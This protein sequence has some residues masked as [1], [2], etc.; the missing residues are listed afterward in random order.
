MSCCGQSVSDGMLSHGGRQVAGYGL[1]GD[2]GLSGAD[3]YAA[4]SD[5]QRTWI[6]GAMQ[7]FED[8]IKSK[9]AGA[10]PAWPQS[11]QTQADVKGA[12]QCTQAWIAAGGNA[13]R[14][15]GVLDEETLCAIQYEAYKIPAFAQSR[16]PDP[17]GKFCKGMAAE[18]K[19]NTML[20]VAGGVAAVVILG[21][22]FYMMRK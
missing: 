11:F 22:A 13:I 18:K 2:F 3:I 9:G 6:V 20:Y 10:C 16:F 15:D 19:S 7:A 14:T 17:S 4:L 5:E 21:G 12:V 1:A 8:A